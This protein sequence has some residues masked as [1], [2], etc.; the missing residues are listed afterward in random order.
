MTIGHEALKQLVGKIFA[1]AG[2][3]AHEA[4][5]IAHYLVEANLTGHD[6]HG[7]I[8]VPRYVE[9]MRAAQVVPNQTA[10]IVLENDVLAVLDGRLGFG[11][12]IG[13]Q[14]MR[15]ALDKSA[16]FGLSLLALRNSGH[17][18]RIGDWAEMAARENKIALIFVNTGGGGILVAP[19][20]APS[21]GFR[22]TRSPWACRFPEARLSCWTHPRAS[23]PKARC[24]WRRTGARTSPR[25]ACSTPKGGRPPTRRTSM[26]PLPAHC[27]PWAATRASRWG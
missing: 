6:S 1:A 9:R 2:S 20:E 23:S 22:L 11:Q 15:I 26:Q 18:G 14:A 21:A 4:E 19:T 16:R 5:R 3:H 12:V 7:V 8:Q 13:E 24:G 17:L 27:F 25:A 10:E